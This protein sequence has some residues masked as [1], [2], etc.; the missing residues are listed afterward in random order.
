M[1]DMNV[2]YIIWL[3]KVEFKGDLGVC[4]PQDFKALQ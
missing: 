2:I 1:R 3:Y 4:K